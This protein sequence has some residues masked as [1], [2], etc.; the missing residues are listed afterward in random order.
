MEQTPNPMKLLSLFQKGKLDTNMCIQ[1][2]YYVKTGI[3]LPQVRRRAWNRSFPCTVRG[4]LALTSSLLSPEIK[5]SVS[6]FIYGPLLKRSPKTNIIRLLI[7]FATALKHLINI[8]LSY[9]YF[10]DEK[11]KMQELKFTQ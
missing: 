4:S 10:A 5:V 8:L 1:K 6:H 2:E 7:Y 3:T 11:T 9:F